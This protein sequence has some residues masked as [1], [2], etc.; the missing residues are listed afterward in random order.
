[1]SR[2]GK[3]VEDHPPLRMA[4]LYPIINEIAD[5]LC[6]FSDTIA[7]QILLLDTLPDHS[8]MDGVSSDCQGL[9]PPLAN[10]DL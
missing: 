7:L 4:L 3:S 5:N 2:R 6:I 1:M 9:C 8:E 10:L